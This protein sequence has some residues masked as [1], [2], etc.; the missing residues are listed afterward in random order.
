VT[1]F[2]PTVTRWVTYVNMPDKFLLVKQVACLG[3]G[4][5]LHESL[6]L[7]RLNHSRESRVPVL[8]GQEGL[9]QTTFSAQDDNG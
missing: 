1:L 4:H 8:V 5:M 6:E 7:P 2:G 9:Q 3:I